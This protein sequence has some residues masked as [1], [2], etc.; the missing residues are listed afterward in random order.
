MEKEF[1]K[2]QNE[3]E[4]DGK[5][6]K[7]FQK[8]L[9]LSSHSKYEEREL[10]EEIEANLTTENI[11]SDLENKEEEEDSEKQRKIEDALKILKYFPLDQSKFTPEREYLPKFSMFEKPT[12]IDEILNSLLFSTKLAFFDNTNNSYHSI[13]REISEDSFGYMNILRENQIEILNFEEKELKKMLELLSGTKITDNLKYFTKIRKEV[14][15]N[16]EDY[17]K[18]LIEFYAIN[19]LSSKYSR[20]EKLNKI[21]TWLDNKI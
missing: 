5:A 1:D 14:K 10:I 4:L 12:K 3:K 16:K 17:L 8:R 15:S 2:K 13:L 19:V 20:T 11:F 21:E 18:E 9:L 7:Y 6:L